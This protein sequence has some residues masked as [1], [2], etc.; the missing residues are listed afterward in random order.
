[1]ALHFTTPLACTLCGCQKLQAFNERE[2][3]LGHL[4][5]HPIR[6][7]AL[8]SGT[9]RGAGPMPGME[10]PSIPLPGHRAAPEP[11]RPPPP[12]AP[13]PAAAPTPAAPPPPS[14]PH[15]AR[16]ASV[17]EVAWPVKGAPPHQR[18]RQRAEPSGQV[19]PPPRGP[20]HPSPSAVCLALRNHAGGTVAA[21]D[22]CLAVWLPATT[23]KAERR[24]ATVPPVRLFWKREV[25]TLAGWK[26]QEARAWNPA[27][28]RACTHE[29][30][31]LTCCLVTSVRSI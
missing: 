22:V 27:C 5:I 9:R 2:R 12:Q 30:F 15:P 1:M 29:Y 17:P 13:A 14:L 16:R 21:E 26:R 25:R 3:E 6:P 31:Q 4:S 18:L 23:A 8:L 10:Y 20:V 7:G 19:P 24:A 11:P 28:C